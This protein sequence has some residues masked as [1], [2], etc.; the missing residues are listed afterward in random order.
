[1]I[2]SAA[3]PAVAM[4]IVK[5][6]VSPRPATGRTSDG[7]RFERSVMDPPPEYSQD[8][9]R[10]PATSTSSAGRRHRPL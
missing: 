2:Q 10:S 9:T 5:N 4:A 1:M 3:A 8:R 7:M 6:V